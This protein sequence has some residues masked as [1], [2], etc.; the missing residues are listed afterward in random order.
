MAVCPVC[1]R[2]NPVPS[3]HCPACGA[4]MTE[5]VKKAAEYAQ[6]NR[7]NV[8]LMGMKWYKFLKYF[9]LPASLLVNG[10]GLYDSIGNLQSLD[11]S[12]YYESLQ[13]AVQV[14]ATAA[15]GLGV[16]VLVLLAVALWG[17]IKKKWIGVQALL[18]GY[19]VNALLGLVMV[20]VLAG[21]Q[22][23][24]EAEALIKST[25]ITQYTSSLIGIAV[26]F[27]LNRVYFNK[28]KAMFDAQ[29]M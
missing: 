9:S 16:V 7:Q 10:V 29:K 18:G 23:A 22:P 2:E 1:K 8:G 25:F 19:I 24:T 4:P 3:T 27:V 15:V 13:Q 21:V 11:L 26:M 28:R 6:Q 5:E 14:E 12:A 17:L 20:V